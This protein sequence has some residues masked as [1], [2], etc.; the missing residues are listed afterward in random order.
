MTEKT[1]DSQTKLE[2]LKI[3]AQ[4]TVA[5]VGNATSGIEPNLGDLF[6]KHYQTVL[7]LYKKEHDCV[8]TTHN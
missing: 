7:N 8:E 2:L 6:E 3:A 1:L 5:S 4:I